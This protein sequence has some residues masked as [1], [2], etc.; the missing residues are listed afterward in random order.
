M[1]VR[2]YPCTLFVA[3]GLMYTCPLFLTLL[4][5]CQFESIFFMLPKD[6]KGNRLVPSLR[7]TN[8]G[9]KLVRRARGEK[10]QQGFHT[11]C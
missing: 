6:G 4:G 9:L 2:C 3:H 10:D 7:R 11:L 8:Q 1:R 5:V